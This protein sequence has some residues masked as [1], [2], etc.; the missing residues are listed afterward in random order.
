LDGDKI[1]L[2]INTGETVIRKDIKYRGNIRVNLIGHWQGGMAEPLWI[3][4]NLENPGEALKI[5]QS[6]MKI[7]ESF[8]DLKSLLKLDKIMNKK[9][10]YLEKM[11]ALVML[12]YAIGLLIGE[13]IRETTYRGKKGENYS[14]LFIFFKHLRHIAAEVIREAISTVTASIRA[15]VMGLIHSNF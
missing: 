2:T 4:T 6:L 5:Y 12:A 3:I 10:E 8:K 7:E 11:I 9:Q 1:A 14:G 15:L 13:R